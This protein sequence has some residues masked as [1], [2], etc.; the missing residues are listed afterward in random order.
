MK[1]YGTLSS[2]QRPASSKTLTLLFHSS[3]SCMLP[4]SI[5]RACDVCDVH[6]LVHI[7]SSLES[8]WVR[9]KRNAVCSKETIARLSFYFG[10]VVLVSLAPP[11][12]PSLSIYLS[13]SLSLFCFR[14]IYFFPF[15]GASLHIQRTKGKVTRGGGGERAT[16]GKI[17]EKTGDESQV[18][19]VRSN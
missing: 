19:S 2:K 12:P 8:I 14:C 4:T 10:Q 18:S 16:Y 5:A 7:L 1:N 15:Q 13:L 6:A 17:E 11:P 9:D 3:S